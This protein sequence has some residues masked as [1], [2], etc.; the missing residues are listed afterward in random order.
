M[1][2]IAF[3]GSILLITG[4]YFGMT[5]HL[6]SIKKYNAIERLSLHMYRATGRYMVVG[7]NRDDVVLTTWFEEEEKALTYAD[8][9]YHQVA[10]GAVEVFVLDRKTREIRKIPKP[11]SGS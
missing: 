2:E 4:I 9:M 3:L 5:L 1:L 6:A 8:L 7:R 10:A 11:Q